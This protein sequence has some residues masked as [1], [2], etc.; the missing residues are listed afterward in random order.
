MAA[1]NRTDEEVGARL[2]DCQLMRGLLVPVPVP[3]SAS[4]RRNQASCARLHDR[5]GWRGGL[6][7]TQL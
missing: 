6:G 4:G 5:F 1:E 7:R 2:P 3:C